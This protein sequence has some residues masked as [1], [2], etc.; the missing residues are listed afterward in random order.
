MCAHIALTHI[1]LTHNLLCVMSNFSW[2]RYLFSGAFITAD[3]KCVFWKGGPLLLSN[4]SIPLPGPCRSCPEGRFLIIDKRNEILRFEKG[5]LDRVQAHGPEYCSSSAQ[6]LR[7]G[8]GPLQF[9]LNAADNISSFQEPAH[10]DWYLSGN[11]AQSHWVFS[12]HPMLHEWRRWLPPY[13]LRKFSDTQEYHPAKSCCITRAV[14][15]LPEFTSFLM[16]T[17]EHLLYT[18]QQARGKGSIGA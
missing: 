1:A 11:S 14:S 4:A 3:R 5:R 13:D 7:Q 12:L 8:T 16:T 18:Q 2:I 17:I 15:S 10:D 9:P 6:Q